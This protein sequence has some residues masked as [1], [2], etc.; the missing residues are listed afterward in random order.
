MT[1]NIAQ[2]HLKGSTTHFACPSSCFFGHDPH[3]VLI[4]SRMASSF[5]TGNWNGN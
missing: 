2:E 1:G 3:M 5:S 4:T